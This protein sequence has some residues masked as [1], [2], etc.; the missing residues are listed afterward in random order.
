MFDEIDLSENE[1][2]TNELVH[3]KPPKK[4]FFHVYVIRPFQKNPWNSLSLVLIFL[5]TLFLFILLVGGRTQAIYLSRFT[6]SDLIQKITAKDKITF[7]LY[8]HCVDNECTN[9][10]MTHNFDKLPSPSDITSGIKI[11]KR[12][13]SV[14]IITN[15]PSNIA[16]D[17]G[18]TISDGA[19]GAGKTISDGAKDAGQTIS[20]GAQDGSKIIKEGAEK[21]GDAIINA[22][23][24]LERMLKEFV[25]FKPKRP[26][27]NFSGLISIPYL[28]ALCSNIGALV[29]LYFQFPTPATLFIFVS[30]IMNGL[31]ILFDLLVFVWVFELIEKIPGIGN[32]KTGPGIWLAGWSATFLCIACLILGFRLYEKLCCGGWIR[33]VTKALKKKIKKMRKPNI[34][35]EEIRKQMLDRV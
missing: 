3:G 11:A 33:D 9:P 16:K 13:F 27:V 6:F 32:Q 31:A 35:E 12:R 29:L 24:L 10:S 4:S 26:T 28:I 14:D 30:A 15:G 22:A 5:S 20:N 25:N 17:A 19:Q 34:S 23:G 7:T 1:K 18:K 2:G 21:A 8:G